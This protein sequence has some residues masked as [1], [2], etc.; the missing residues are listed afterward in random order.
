MELAGK[1]AIITGA[2]LGI[3]LATARTFAQAGAKIVLAARSA[4]K[5]VALTGELNAQGHEALA[6]CAAMRDAAAVR[7]MATRAFEHYGRILLA[8]QTE[9][10]EQFME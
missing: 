4:G 2:S 8:A 1:V 3:G 6:L 5:L 9:P 7:A 10:Q